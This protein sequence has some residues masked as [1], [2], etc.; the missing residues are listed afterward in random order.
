MFHSTIR[1]DKMLS[2]HI[3]FTTQTEHVV[4]EN[5]AEQRIYHFDL[6][7]HHPREASQTEIT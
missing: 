2:G 3:H 7:I 5:D 6:Q 1:Y 4:Y